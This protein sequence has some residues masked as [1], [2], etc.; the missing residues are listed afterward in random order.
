MILSMKTRCLLQLARWILLFWREL[1]PGSS[2]ATRLQL[3]E[4]D[5]GTSDGNLYA[6]L[7]N[8][9]GSEKGWNSSNIVVHFWSCGTPSVII[10][11]TS[12]M[13][14]QALQYGS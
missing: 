7:R 4:S 3:E 2:K 8:L 10:H 13:V 14:M 11:G 9:K 5:K 6:C 1:A 12:A